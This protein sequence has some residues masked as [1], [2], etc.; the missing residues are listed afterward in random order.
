MCKFPFPVPPRPRLL[1]M[2]CALVPLLLSSC[3]GGDAAK[4]KIIS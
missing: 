3:G 2:L 1:L 4:R